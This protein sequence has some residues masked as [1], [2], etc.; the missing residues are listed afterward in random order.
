MDRLRHLET[1]KELMSYTM[2]PKSEFKIWR[3]HNTTA[4]LCYVAMGVIAY[5]VNPVNNILSTILVTLLAFCSGCVFYMKGIDKGIRYVGETRE[6]LIEERK[7]SR[8]QN[9]DK[10]MNNK[11]VAKGVVTG[12]KPPSIVRKNIDS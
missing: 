1:M 9:Y 6:A 11:R 3:Y 2:K 8:Q 7:L 12:E 4:I 10:G 5:F